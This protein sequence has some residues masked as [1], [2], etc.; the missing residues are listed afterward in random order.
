MP[1]WMAAMPDDHLGNLPTGRQSAGVPFLVADPATNGRRGAVAI[2][3]ARVPR[4]RLRARRAKAGSIYV[5][6]SVGNAGN[7]KVAGA[8][9]FVYEDGTEATQ[10]AVQDGTSPAGGTRRSRARGRVATARRDTRPS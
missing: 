7:H 2:S 4:A 10:Y 3:R 6:H 1:G 9:T 8:I 5:L